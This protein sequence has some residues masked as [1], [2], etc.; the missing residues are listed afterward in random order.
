MSWLSV[1]RTGFGWGQ[2]NEG[3]K[4]EPKQPGYWWQDDCHGSSGPFDDDFYFLW[5][6]VDWDLNGTG[7]I[8]HGADRGPKAQVCGVHSVGGQFAYTAPTDWPG[9]FCE[10]AKLRL[11]DLGGTAEKHDEAIARSART[12]YELHTGGKATSRR[13]NLFVMTGQAEGVGDPFW[14]EYASEKQA[15]AIPV[16]DVLLGSLGPLGSDGRLY[17]FLPDGESYDV[18]PTVLGNTYYTYGIP[19]PSKHKLVHLTEC[20]A[21]TNPD[22]TRTTVGVGEYVNFSFVQPINMSIP[23]TPHWET[24]AG[25]VD[26][27]TGEGT[28]FT[29]PS[30]GVPATVTVHVRDVKIETEFEVKEPSG[31]DH[32]V[33]RKTKQWGGTQW[34]YAEAFLT[35]FIAPTDVSFSRVEIEEV[36]MNVWFNELL[37]HLVAT[38]CDSGQQRRHVHYQV[39]NLGGTHNK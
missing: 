36:G 34:G 25:S 9:E 11:Y 3:I 18:T 39:W 19:E 22:N 21:L 10:V 37:E 7:T 17:T 1:G 20:T 16:T 33:V 13:S 31:V 32:A 23:E 38:S 29:A 35:V 24:T 30:N 5:F 2:I 12:L 4:W 15:Y 26:P 8:Y 28:R 27:T 6:R 14:W